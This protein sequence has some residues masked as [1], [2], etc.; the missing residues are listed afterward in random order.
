MAMQDK[1]IRIDWWLLAILAALITVLGMVGFTMQPLKP[2]DAPLGPCDLLYRSVQLFTLESGAV[3]PPVKWPLEFARWLAP[4]VTSFAA[5]KGILALIHRRGRTYLRL[6]DIQQHGIVCGLGQKGL[7]LASELLDRGEP[8]VVIERDP[9]HPAL[10]G[11]SRRGAV[12]LVG[13]ARDS[14]LLHEAR[15]HT[16]HYLFATT[17]TDA[18][19]IDITRK[20]SDLI[21]H[22]A[23]E[24][25]TLDCYAHVA[26]P[27][28]KTLFYDHPLFAESRKQFN[29]QLFNLYDR[30]ARLLFED[31]ALD[32]TRPIRSPA[33]PQARILLFGCNPVAISLVLQ[34]A[35]I[36]HYANQKKLA[37]TIVDELATRQLA[38][39]ALSVPALTEILDISTR[40]IPIE[41]LKTDDLLKLTDDRQ[42]TIYLCAATDTR[43]VTLAR[44]LQ[45]LLKDDTVPVVAVLL[46][47]D[48]LADLL[49]S[50]N[51]TLSPRISV[52]PL[53]HNTLALDQILGA[54]QDRAA[55]IIHDMYCEDRIAHGESL[56]SNPSLRPWDD[57][58]EGIKDS[59]REQ[60]D[61]LPVKLRAIG[62][63][64]DA[65]SNNLR[66]F[67]LTPQQIQLLSEME[68]RRWMAGKRL[69][70]WRHA[71][72][73]RNRTLKLDPLLVKFEQLPEGEQH[74][75]V[76]TVESIP[77][78]LTRLN[79]FP[80]TN[81]GI[82]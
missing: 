3:D 42:D 72:G 46:Q 35:H 66:D 9:Q 51:T 30:G 13:D 2:G 58:P 18:C 4:L 70:G 22:D 73:K 54:Q 75:D 10:S 47:T 63:T 82:R 37:V 20:A 23:D 78:L 49:G 15:L 33:D 24:N 53:I 74:K 56:E 17:D 71:S 76:K 77:E 65:V 6:R 50:D 52:F 40:D 44:R 80:A 69:D 27:A 31:F 25:A 68:H 36:G 41:G 12:T 55:R 61:H 60:A 14:A 48:A 11:L 16:A 8:V 67:T 57:Q 5:I 1:K 59:N 38:G 28:T 21:S 32:R 62:L 79:K 64:V 19:N 81:P 34:A 26:D 29:A 43:T 45:P 7:H 39:L